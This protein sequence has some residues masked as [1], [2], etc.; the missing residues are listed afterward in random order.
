MIL[1]PQCKYGDRS[2]FNLILISN[3]FQLFLTHPTIS[4]FLPP[5]DHTEEDEN[6]TIKQLRAK[7]DHEFVVARK[8]NAMVVQIILQCKHPTDVTVRM[9]KR[10]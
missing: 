2:S 9:K 1:I 5:K 10:F 8:A 7:D 4:S 6:E 3:Y